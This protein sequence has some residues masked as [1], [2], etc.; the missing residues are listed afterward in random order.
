[1]SRIVGAAVPK[2]RLIMKP[3]ARADCALIEMRVGNRLQVSGKYNRRA[4]VKSADTIY[5]S[6]PSRW[7]LR[8]LGSSR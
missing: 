3:P 8:Q 1:M 6:A 4:G 5:S 7:A 2:E